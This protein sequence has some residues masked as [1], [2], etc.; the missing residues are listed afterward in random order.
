MLQ[1]S[2]TN[3]SPRFSFCKA[4]RWAATRSFAARTP[5]LVGVTSRKSEIL[6]DHYIIVSIC[7]ND[8]TYVTL[9]NQRVKKEKIFPNTSPGLENL[10][11]EIF[12]STRVWEN[13]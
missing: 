11:K 3:K 5:K 9:S 1:P 12:Y 8:K 10:A 7:H 2:I 13:I 4:F 6:S